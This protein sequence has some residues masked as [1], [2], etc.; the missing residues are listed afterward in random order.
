[1]VFWYI[2]LDLDEYEIGRKRIKHFVWNVGDLFGKDLFG[3][4]GFSSVH[5]N[6][7]SSRCRINQENKLGIS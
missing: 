1:V 6:S 5:E 3:F 4:V 7:Q 2:N